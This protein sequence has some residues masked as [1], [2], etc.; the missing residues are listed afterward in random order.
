MNDDF[1]IV[2][3]AIPFIPYVERHG[4]EVKRSGTHHKTRCI[5]HDDHDPSLVLYEDSYHCFAC[6]ASGDVIDYAMKLNNWDKATALTELAREYNITLTPLSAE[7]AAK[8]GRR[9]RL[10]ALMNDAAEYYDAL[11]Y[12]GG[13]RLNY[14]IKDRGLSEDT[15]KAAKMGYAPGNMVLYK[16]M[17]QLGYTFQDLLDTG[18]IKQGDERPYDTFSN[19]IVIPIYDHKGRIVAFSGRAMSKDHSPKYLH[20][21]T[22]EIFDKSKI[23]H[24]T[25]MSRVKNTQ[26]QSLDTLVVVEGTLDPISALNRGFVNIASLLGKSMSDDQLL[27]LCAPGITR[28]VFCLDNDQAGHTALRRLVEKHMHV[29]ASKGVDLYAM[30]APFGKDPDDTFREKPE[31]WQPAVDAARPVTEVLIDREVTALGASPTPGSLSKMARELLPILKSDNPFAQKRAVQYL[32]D[33]VDIAYNDLKAWLDPI[34]VLPR[35]VNA[36]MSMA[37]YPNLPSVELKVL[38]GILV[39]EDPQRWL[40]R[41]NAVLGKM[42]FPKACGSLSQNDFTDTR[43][44]GIMVLITTATSK[45]IRPFDDEVRMQIG[46]GHLNETY[47]RA[48]CAPE[49]QAVFAVSDQRPAFVLSYDDFLKAVY[50]LRHLRL[51]ADITHKRI[52]GTDLVEWVKCKLYLW[53][54]AQK[55]YALS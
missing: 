1:R 37:K 19:R 6:H 44:R 43:T 9:E 45:G 17:I 3:D 29:A 48:T 55:G 26:G 4:G 23:I 39:N 41:A 47:Y 8:Q 50:L 10:Y 31:L 13:P 14:L 40:D 33:K 5:F 20:N 22:T 16:Q 30:Q 35:P 7:H 32:A 52:P 18:L 25:P 12:T 11:L 36:P 49:V 21:A 46:N 28:L 42:P 34:R 54:L 51:A 27:L 38:H 24:M 2:K 53:Q 15:I